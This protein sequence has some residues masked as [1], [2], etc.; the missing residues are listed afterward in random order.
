MSDAI[1]T[2]ELGIGCIAYESCDVGQCVVRDAIAA[3][4]DACAKIAEEVARGLVIT[5]NHDRG[6]S[7]ASTFIA[8][9]IRARGQTTPD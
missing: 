5:S 8:A 2:C 1:K 3:E 4:R 6:L 9:A 7:Q